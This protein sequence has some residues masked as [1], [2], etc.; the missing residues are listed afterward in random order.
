MKSKTRP[1]DLII[2]EYEN[3]D[4]N[5]PIKII[6]GSDQNEIKKLKIYYVKTF[7]RESKRIQIYEK[8]RRFPDEKIKIIIKNDES[9]TNI[10]KL[11]KGCKN[12]KSVN[13]DNFDFS[14]IKTEDVK[15]LFYNCGDLLIKPDLKKYENN[16]LK[17]DDIYGTEDEEEEIKKEEE[18]KEEERND[19]QP[20]NV[21]EIS[22]LYDYSN[23]EDLLRSTEIVR[24]RMSNLGEQ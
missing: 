9:I 24:I 22:D 1:N 7:K 18:K 11:F 14:N 21:E 5:K 20:I 3:K 19:F 23:P 13:F 8:K 10:S 17:F 2:C 4:I 6:Q 12:L 16:N 15:G